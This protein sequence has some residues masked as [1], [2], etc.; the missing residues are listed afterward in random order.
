[1]PVLVVRQ[2]QLVHDGQRRGRALGFGHRDGAVQP[3]HRGTGL[4][5]ELAVEQRDLRPVEP[6]RGLQG[7][8]RRLDGVRPAGRALKGPVEQGA[9]L[10]EL[11]PVPPRPVLIGQQ[12]QVLT[13][14]PG[15]PA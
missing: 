5:G 12:H 1:V 8:D 11:A 4:L 2:V 3:D 13:V 10:S 9:A 7:R 6:L 15:V 14:E